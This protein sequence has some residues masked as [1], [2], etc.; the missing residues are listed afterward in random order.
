MQPGDEL[1]LVGNFARIHFIEN[2]GAAFG[3][4]FTDFLATEGDELE[5]RIRAKRWLTLISLFSVL[6]ILALLIRVRK[7]PRLSW[8]IALVLGGAVGNMTDRIFYGLWF[9]RINDYE[10]G[11]MMG[12]VV[13]LFHIDLWTGKLPA[14]L[15]LVGGK[16]LSLLPVFNLADIA[17]LLGIFAVMWYMFRSVTQSETDKKNGKN[18]Q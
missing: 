10:G 1:R 16:Q 15:P 11:L 3:V 7:I 4:T 13:D 8:F 18:E 6:L 5:A 12:R 9:A 14:G 17:I 2:E